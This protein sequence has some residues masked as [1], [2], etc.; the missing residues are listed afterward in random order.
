VVG[1]IA[2][3]V[4]GAVAEHVGWLAGFALLALLAAAG[5]RLLAPLQAQE[6]HGWARATEP[7][8]AGHT[9]GAP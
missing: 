9:A 7:G 4:F 5:W 1:A 6:R 3:V 2:P 8:A